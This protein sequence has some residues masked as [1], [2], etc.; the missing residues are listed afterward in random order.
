MSEKKNNEKINLSALIDQVQGEV[1]EL[2]GKDPEEIIEQEFAS[3][4]TEDDIIET[5]KFNNFDDEDDEIKGIIVDKKKLLGEEDEDKPN[6]LDFSKL[7]PETM[8]HVNETLEEVDKMI[9]IYEEDMGEEVAEYMK[10]Q[11]ALQKGEEVEDEDDDIIDKD[12]D[13]NSFKE[14]YEEAIV[15]IDK[16]GMGSVIDF[17][18]DEREKLEKVKKIKLEEVETIEIPKF[19]TKKAKKG[20]AKKIINKINTVRS[21]PIVLP[22][23]GLTMDVTGCSTY[24][25]LTLIN[26]NQDDVVGTQRSRWSLLHSKVLNTSIGKLDFNQFLDN[27]AQMEYNILVYG[28][29]CATYPELDKFPLTCPKCGQSFDHEYTIRGLLRAEEISDKMMEAIQHTVDCSHT[30]EDAKKCHE[31][32]IL[33]V[34]ETIKLPRS[35]YYFTIGVQTAYDFI[36]SSM[37]VIEDIDEKYAQ[38][39]ILASAVKAVYVEDPDDGEYYQLEDQMDIIEVIYS[40]LDTDLLVL[41]QKIGKLVDGMSYSFGLMDVTCDNRTCRRHVNTI[42]VELEDILFHKYRQVMNTNIE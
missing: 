33:S 42:P 5:P 21:T 23:S 13:E 7:N 15:V 1:D 16:T 6:P 27:V 4:E 29:L 25:L 32:S 35:G 9:D 22:V 26:N 11:E 2:E 37:T 39:A 18:E 14:K 28:V 34:N 38:S 12:T 10:K 17:T 3:D 41:G 24:E 8:E 30:V 31:E 19:K 20:S 36:E 40:L